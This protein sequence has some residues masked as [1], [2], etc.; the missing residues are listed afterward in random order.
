MKDLTASE[1]SPRL[2]AMRLNREIAQEL[3]VTEDDVRSKLTDLCRQYRTANKLG[4]CRLARKGAL[5]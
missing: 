3:G 2:A 5:Q 4:L 1:L